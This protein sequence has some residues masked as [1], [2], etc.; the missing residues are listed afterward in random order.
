M[1]SPFLAGFP[2]G[3]TICDFDTSYALFVEFIKKGGKSMISLH[4]Q[5]GADMGNN[6]VLVS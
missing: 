6:S 5:I 3:L 2:I 4:Y 1:D